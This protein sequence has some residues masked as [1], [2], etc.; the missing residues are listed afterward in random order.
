MTSDD[1]SEDDASSVSNSTSILFSN[2]DRAASRICVG[3]FEYL[4]GVVLVPSGKAGA[5]PAAIGTNLADAAG[6]CGGESYITPEGSGVVMSGWVLS[7]GTGELSFFIFFFSSINA[8]P[9]LF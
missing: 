9:V 7:T 6:A 1:D 5:S 2:L 4:R 8:I 3:T